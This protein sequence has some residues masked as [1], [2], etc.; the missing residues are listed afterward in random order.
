M[1]DYRCRIDKITNLYKIY[2][3]DMF[4]YQLRE[5]ILDEQFREIFNEIRWAREIKKLGSPIPEKL[6]NMLGKLRERIVDYYIEYLKNNREIKKI[7][8]PDLIIGLGC[9]NTLGFLDKRVEVL[10]K[11][12]E[13]FPEARVL[14]SGGGMGVLKTEAGEMLEKLK[15]NYK[16]DEKLII[17]EE[18]SLDTLGNI[19]FSKLLLK[20]MNILSGI[21]KIIV[22]TSPFHVIR[23]HSLFSRVFPK[24]ISFEI[25]GHDYYLNKVS[26]DATT[27]KIVE[28]EI[29]SLYRSDRI[30]N[31]V[32]LKEEKK[33]NFK[34]DETSIFY[35]MLL[36]HDLYKN[37]RDI[38]R[39]YYVC[40]ETYKI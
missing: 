19:V 25:R 13:K 3:Y 31:I 6:L 5:G 20:K 8:D 30:F 24:E 16:A 21:E 2:D 39:K 29:K 28:N 14:L 26:N 40:L 34:V 11:L 4:F 32:N 22:V 15:K 33:N 35:Q 18:D 12:V 17:L 36:Y 38:L 9:S 23:V 10:G 7:K 27:R 1:V 37:R